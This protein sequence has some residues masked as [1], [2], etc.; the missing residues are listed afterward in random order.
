[1]VSIIHYCNQC[2][3]E[4]S[5]REK[6]CKYCGT[7][8]EYRCALP[9]FP[10]ASEK[11]REIRKP[12]PVGKWILLYL[13][14]TV[15]IFALSYFYFSSPGLQAWSLKETKPAVAPVQ[16]ETA[17][18]VAAQVENPTVLLK[19]AYNQLTVGVQKTGVLYEESKKV[20]VPGDPK[21]TA[22]NY[23]GVL[24]NTDAL[25]AQLTI[26]PGSSSEVMAVVVPLKESISLLGKSVSIMADYLDGKLS[27]SPPNPD[28]VARS[29]EFS[30]QGQARLKE[31]QQALSELRKKIE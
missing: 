20:N 23:R 16:S 2:G 17:V 19:S 28:W 10:P 4:I 1:M 26:P 13:F 12:A 9:P 5:H 6:F 27:L 30:V 21:R 11:R 3:R 22:D 8:I 14:S 31:T 15:C 29:Q 7:K 25:L 18:S 24:R